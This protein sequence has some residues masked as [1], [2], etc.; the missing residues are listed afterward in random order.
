[1]LFLAALEVL[2]VE[3]RAVTW[4]DLTAD[5]S[6]RRR[7][8]TALAFLLTALNYAALTGYDLL[9]FAY[10]GKAL[11]RAQIAAGV[12]SGVRDLQQRRVRDAVRRLRALSLLHAL[13]RDR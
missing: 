1:M 5:V 2:R 12:V 8:Q 3:L 6:A 10:I 4:H 7:S 13:G 11:P 9:A